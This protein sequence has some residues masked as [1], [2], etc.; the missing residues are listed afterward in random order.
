MAQKQVRKEGKARFRS[1]AKPEWQ[2]GIAKERI[3]TLLKQAELNVK[4]SP[5]YSRRYVELMRK[6]AMRYTIRLPK[7]IKRRICNKC[8]TLLVA[9]EN[10]TVRTSPKQQAVIITCKNCTSIQRFPYRREK[11]SKTNL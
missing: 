10:C 8:N 5:A 2:T 6:I 9:E 1:V 3:K 4:T 11:K 7:T